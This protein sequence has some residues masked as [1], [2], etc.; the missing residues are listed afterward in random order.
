MKIKLSIASQ[1]SKGSSA[2]VAS[3]SVVMISPEG[4]QGVFLMSPVIPQR[5]LGDVNLD[6]L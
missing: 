6:I 4:A 5:S 2:N 3:R 1:K